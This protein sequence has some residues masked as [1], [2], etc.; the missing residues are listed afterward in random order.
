MFKYTLFKWKINNISI[1]YQLT[2]FLVFI[3]LIECVPS[4]KQTQQLM[5]L[6]ALGRRN[7]LATND[8]EG[9]IDML[10]RS[11]YKIKIYQSHCKRRKLAT[12]TTKKNL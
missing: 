2:I 12:I 3:N 11:T 6:E 1:L 9:I 8:A 10:G 5:L 4:E 7:P